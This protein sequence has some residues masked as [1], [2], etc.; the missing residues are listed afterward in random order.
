MDKV[1]LAGTIGTWVA[2]FLALVALIAVVGPVLVWLAARSERSK[3]LDIA[4]GAIQ[5]FIS[6]G[7][8]FIGTNVRIFRRVR[9][10]ILTKEPDANFIAPLSWDAARYSETKSGATWAQLAQLLRGYG[11][12]FSLG[13]DLIIHHGKALLPVHRIWILAIGLL[14]RYSPQTDIPLERKRTLSIARVPSQVRFQGLD[15]EGDEEEESET[16][17]VRQRLSGTTGQMKI[18]ERE[19]NQDSVKN[20]QLLAFLGNPLSE[21]SKLQQEHLTMGDLLMLALGCMPLPK[22]Q[23]CTLKELV[24]LQ[25]SQIDEDEWSGPEERMHKRPRMLS[26]PMGRSASASSGNDFPAP[27]M[28]RRHPGS[29][30]RV[31][32]RK[33]IAVPVET[34]IPLRLEKVDDVDE[35]MNQILK[36]FGGVQREI[37]SL[38]ASKLDNALSI[39]LKEY[40]N[41][42]YVPPTAEWVRLFHTINSDDEEVLTLFIWRNDAQKIAYGLLSLAWHPEGYLFGG[43][44]QG[45][46][47]QLLLAVQPKLHYLLVRLRENVQLL[48]LLEPEKRKLAD[49]LNSA[50]RQI[51]K[52]R[53]TFSR[54]TYRVLYEL[55]ESLSSSAHQVVEVS[56]M[57]GVLMMTSEEFAF[58]AQQSARYFAKSVE[59]VVEVDL[60]SGIVK[61]PLPFGGLQNFTVDL[62]SLYEN[63]VPRDETVQ[64][65]Y[66]FVMLACL[67]ACLRSFLLSIRFDGYPLMREILRMDD[68]VHIA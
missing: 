19:S 44:A 60:R 36:P 15:N 8:R 11:V 46:C 56:H 17:T 14:G 24:P 55:D 3:A 21:L 29:S 38:E 45:S 50:E 27:S 51:R 61:V 6:K 68:I 35:E 5:P 20:I 7:F 30:Q 53:E 4:G 64:V 59:S 42:T 23:V 54:S 39:E 26:I 63:W 2:V 52:G 34:P 10:P 25:T 47:M 31:N 9:A 1:G 57:I 32:S 49:R 22:G 40:M 43:D 33:T 58:L 67:R 37:L 13:D 62:D 65:K 66:T 28:T 48:S 41:M 16:W 18:S 12:Q